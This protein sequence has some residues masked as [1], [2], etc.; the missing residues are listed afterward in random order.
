MAAPAFR[1]CRHCHLS[2][3]PDF[4]QHR[5][6]AE[7]RYFVKIPW[8]LS[9]RF[10]VLLDFSAASS[11]A[12]SNLLSSPVLEVRKS[13]IVEGFSVLLRSAMSSTPTYID[14]GGLGGVS[15]RRRTANFDGSAWLYG[16][17]KTRYLGERP[18]RTANVS[19]QPLSYT[20]SSS[21]EYSWAWGPPKVMKL[22]V[23]PQFPQN[24]A[25]EFKGSAT[26]GM[27]Q[28]RAG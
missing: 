7:R 26:L 28:V 17:G 10:S 12:R 11:A 19:Q 13:S 20:L 1:G 6:Q 23:D 22:A 27:T 21:T 16:Q 18:V 4:I 8:S 24:L 14:A 2:A 5:R 3:S 9:Y 25:F 15:C